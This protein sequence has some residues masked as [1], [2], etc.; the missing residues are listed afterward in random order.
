E[1]AVLLLHRGEHAVEVREA[2]D[3]PLHAGDVL[4][5]VSHRLIEF[6]LAAAGDEDVGPFGD[7]PPGGGQADAA[8]APADGPDFPFHF[9]GHWSP[10]LPARAVRV[11]GYEYVWPP[12]HT[13]TTTFP[14]C[15]FD[16]R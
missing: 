6:R 8:V 12:H 13:L 1:V 11:T 7:E 15:W 2:R 10:P 9:L 4:A 14:I 3:V 5:D 16:S